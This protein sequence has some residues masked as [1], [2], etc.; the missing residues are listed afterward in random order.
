MHPTD[1]PRAHHPHPTRL[2]RALHG[3]LGII[4]FP[5]L[6]I[7]AV[8]GFYLTN[9]ALFD[10][11]VQ[12]HRQKKESALPK[13]PAA[14]VAVNRDVAMAM[15]QQIFPNSQ[16]TRVREYRYRQRDCW[17]VEFGKRR[18]IV[19]IE[20]ARYHV[21]DLYQ[22]RSYTP[23]KRLL[24]QHW[25]WRYLIKRLHTARILGD[26]GILVADIVSLALLLFSLSGVYLWVSPRW[27][28]F[29]NRGK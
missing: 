17:S 3:W 26:I 12:E 22:T 19:E 7:L 28:R 25:H 5:L 23:D 6:A 18:V 10:D 20:T 13:A 29:R 4:F 27:Q 16:L 2:I 1:P 21:V 11:I 9:A 24:D 8:T 14:A 15:A